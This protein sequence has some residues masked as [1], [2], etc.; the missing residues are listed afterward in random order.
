MTR[1]P[2]SS[3]AARGADREPAR[4]VQAHARQ[5]LWTLRRLA[6]PPV[7]AVLLSYDHGVELHLYCGGELRRQLCFLRELPPVKYAERLR[8]KL[9]ARGYT[10]ARR[11]RRVER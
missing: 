2:S 5:T 4:V 3:A 7:T 1:R 11:D 8:G 9:E 6:G 10:E